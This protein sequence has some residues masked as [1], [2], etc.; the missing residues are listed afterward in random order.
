MQ[1]LFQV[2]S[3]KYIVPKVLNNSGLIFCVVNIE[4]FLM[5]VYIFLF[6]APV[7]G[8]PHTI[9]AGIAEWASQV[10]LHKL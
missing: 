1:V 10:M 2:S 9:I 7:S 6:T 3:T 8:N 4:Q 5:K